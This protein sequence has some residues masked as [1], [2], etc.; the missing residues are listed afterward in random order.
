MAQ[1]KYVEQQISE[2]VG[3]ALAHADV[4]TTDSTDAIYRLPVETYS[5]RSWDEEMN[6]IFRRVPLMLGLSAELPEPRS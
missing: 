6:A 3:R 4:G 2:M 1:S 5:P